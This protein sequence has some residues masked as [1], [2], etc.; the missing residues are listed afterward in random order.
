MTGLASILEIF[1]GA[2]REEKT[3]AVD[4]SA[5]SE[6]LRGPGGGID[7][8]IPAVVVDES[9]EEQ[10]AAL[11]PGEFVWDAMSVAKFGDGDNEFG[12]AMLDVLRK[13]EGLMEEVKSLIRSRVGQNA[14]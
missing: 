5:M 12:A 6:P 10:P 2:P 14:E 7:D 8:L 3:S 9:G 1:G 4:V 11:S 13:D